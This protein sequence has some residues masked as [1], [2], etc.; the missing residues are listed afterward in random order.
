MDAAKRR[1]PMNKKLAIIAITGMLAVSAAV[2]GVTYALFTA[3]STNTGNLVQSGKLDITSNR[4]DYPASGP[5]FYTSAQNQ[6]KGWLSI[7]AWAPGD[8]HTRGLFLRNIGTLEARMSSVFARATDDKGN[9]ISNGPQYNDDIL[10]ATNAH[11]KIWSLH[12]DTSKPNKKNISLFS[13]E[14]KDQVM[15]VVN[16][17]YQKW[18]SANN[19]ISGLFE[20]Y[21]PIIINYINDYMDENQVMKGLN[22][23]IVNVFDKSLSDL[24]TPVDVS[25]KDIRLGANDVSMLAFTVELN[26]DAKNELQEKKVYFNFGTNWTQTKNNDVK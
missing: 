5:M 10:F 1:I 3:E 13:E 11:V 2:G 24:L 21:A 4:V 20:Q 8:V 23:K 26:R 22:I 18:L 6:Y 17:G 14:E 9:V 7:D 16:E 15:A 19:S 12:Q 25:K